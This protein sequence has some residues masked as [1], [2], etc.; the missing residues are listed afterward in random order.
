MK[1]YLIALFILP[2]TLC[3]G[4]SDWNVD[5]SGPIEVNGHITHKAWH[6]ALLH[7]TLDNTYQMV[8][9]LQ[10]DEWAFPVFYPSIAASK[11]Y[12]MPYETAVK[13]WPDLN[14]HDY[15]FKD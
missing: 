13:I 12:K 15:G 5:T 9:F 14:E 4:E 11:A 8:R 1:K 2:F 3:F 7:N 10:N 6:F